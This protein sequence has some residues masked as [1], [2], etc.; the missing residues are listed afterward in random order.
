MNSSTSSSDTDPGWARSLIACLGTLIGG[1]LLILALMVV[2]DPYDSGKLGLLG[3]A[4]VES[5]S[6]QFTAASRARDPDFNAAIFGNS[7]AQMIE[8]AELSRATG[9]RFVQLYMT[10]A[11]PREQLA[12]LDFFLRHHNEVGALVFAADPAWCVHERPKEEGAPFPYWVYDRG[13]VTYAIRLISWPAIEQV[14]QRLGIGLGWRQRM[15]RDGFVSYE[16]IWPPGRFN[17]VNRPRDPAAAATAAARDVFSEVAALHAVIRKLPAD[18]PVV[19]VVPPTFAPTV[20]K[21]GT[22]AALERGACDAALRKVV[23]GRPRSNFINYRVDNAMTR[24]QANFADLIHYRASLA[25]RIE[26]GIVASL[27]FGEQARI[28]F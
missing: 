23:A 20:A 13:I 14:F 11:N 22:D 5:R 4:G 7:T 25:R 18:V 15:R 12:V 3:I 27:K 1:A 9:L 16:D 2:V 21:P 28:D 6:T 24:D 17:A 19:I 10:G 26:E 8:P